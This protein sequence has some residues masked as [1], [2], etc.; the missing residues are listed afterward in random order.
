MQTDMCTPIFHIDIIHY[1]QKRK[2][3]KC[4]WMYE[5]INK[6][7]YSHTMEYYLVLKKAEILTQATIWMN[8]EDVM[9][10]EISQS[11]TN[12]YCMIPL[13]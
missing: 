10:S 12:K 4:P 6:M 9:L 7:W 3:S 11:Q 13:T 2:P 8:S 5:W 1:S